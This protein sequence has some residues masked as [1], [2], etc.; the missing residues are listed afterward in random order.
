MTLLVAAL[1]L[2]LAG[3]LGYTNP[4]PGKAVALQL[5]GMHLAKVRRNLV[6]APGRGLDVYRPRAADIALPAVLF[7]HGSS[8]DASPKD[9]GL[10][11][12]WGQ[13]AAASGVAGVTFNHN[14]VQED[15]E[16]AIRYVRRNGGRLGIDG[17][18]LCLA[19]FSAGV[20]PAMLVALKST[21]G[22]LRCAVGYYG[23]LDAYYAQ[24]SPRA[25]LTATSLPI[26]IAKAGIDAQGLNSSID[27]FVARA[28]KVGAPV[29]L[30]VHE[31]GRH[32]FDAAE[33][34]PRARA[35][36][37]RTLAFFRVHLRR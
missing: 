20:T 37:R 24:A 32:V 34:D 27:R 12:G 4:T 8:R 18:R 33:N 21:A 23:F 2:A 13:L 19:S 30:V 1:A 25:Q 14:G 22:E 36:V 26:L 9:G 28:R 29:E 31:R 17:D 15:I 5:P 3:P 35:I 7:V 6:Y 16:G 10:F 11:V